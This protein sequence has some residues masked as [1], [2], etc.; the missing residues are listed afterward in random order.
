[1]TGGLLDA[2]FATS[3]VAAGVNFPARTV[4]FLNSD[5]F[6]GREFLPL[7]PTEFHQ[8]TGRA[9]RRGMDH[10]GFALA[11]PGKFMDSRMIAKLMSSPPA[12][13]ISQ[14]RV[15]F[16]MVLN[17][18][19]SHSP[20]Q[21]RELLEKS[22]ASYLLLNR[23]KGPEFLTL[24]KNGH[25]YLW[26][27]FLRH[28]H[29]LKETGYVSDDDRLTEL[30]FQEAALRPA[31]PVGRKHTKEFSGSRSSDLTV[32]DE[33]AEKRQSNQKSVGA[34]TGIGHQ[35][36]GKGEQENRPCAHQDH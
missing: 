5:K 31:Q 17:L 35:S 13:V 6:N 7:S 9:G 26:H 21:I 11:I 33:Q 1:M 32:G 10:I 28:L 34:A 20:E 4:V 27:D 12:D 24:Q 22:F 30:R 36:Q 23:K 14:I 25:R 3:T 19:L 16:S 15:N 2:V 8:M 29:F 18:L